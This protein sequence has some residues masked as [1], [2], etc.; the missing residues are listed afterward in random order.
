MSFA[1]RRLALAFIASLAASGAAI[2]T[3]SLCDAGPPTYN[4]Q[5][6]KVWEGDFDADGK[7]VPAPETGATA[8]EKVVE[9]AE[10]AE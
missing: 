3:P 10:N 8:P 1:P 9:P 7:P 6:A 4:G 5:P 2:A